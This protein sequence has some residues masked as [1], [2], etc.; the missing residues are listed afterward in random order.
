MQTPDLIN[1]LFETGGAVAAWRNF[2]QLRRD[3]AIKGVYW[4]VYVFYSLW[5]FWNLAYY[6][7]LN[8]WLSFTAGA[9]LVAGNVAWVITG[10][11]VIYGSYGVKPEDPP[12]ETV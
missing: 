7:M 8:Q 1:G 12:H 5:G 10:L 9:V 11:R 3:R 4:P 6:P 2:F